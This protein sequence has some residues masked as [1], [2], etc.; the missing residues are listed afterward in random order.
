MRM[1][2]VLKVELGDSGIAAFSLEPGG[3]LTEAVKSMF[4]PDVLW[5]TFER[6][7]YLV[8]ENVP[9]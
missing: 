8:T 9:A 3:V 7:D 5:Q 2:G 6:G 1:A 4:P